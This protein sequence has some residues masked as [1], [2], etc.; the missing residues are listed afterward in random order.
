MTCPN[1]G[2]CK[3]NLILV[4]PNPTSCV[5]CLSLLAYSSTFPWGGKNAPLFTPSWSVLSAM[6]WL[7]FN[8]FTSQALCFFIRKWRQLLL[9][10]RHF[11]KIVLALISLRKLRASLVID[12]LNYFQLINK[13]VFFFCSFSKHLILSLS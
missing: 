13:M 7:H 5:S 8:C 11:S 10:P 12:G 3:L 4:A 1:P 2:L 9:A 6:I